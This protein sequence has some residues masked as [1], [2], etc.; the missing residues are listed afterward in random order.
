MP[1]AEAISAN[2]HAW[3][4]IIAALAKPH[5]REAAAR[6]MLGAT[7]DDAVEP[8]PLAKCDRVAETLRAAGLV[9]PETGRFD[10]RVVA[11]ILAVNAVAPRR[12]V[13][14]YLVGGR[15]A[16]YPA[17]PDARRELLSEVARRAF[18]PDEVLNERAIN[19]R[20]AVFSDDVAV[21]RRYL[22]DQELL[23]RRADGSEYALVAPAADSNTAE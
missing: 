13:D 17:N 5:S 4:P 10:D 20:L 1:H 11:R 21:L 3:R 14:R 22:V 8:L 19:E 7:L 9:D 2:P 18:R 16:Q 23:E 15:I 6:L 12:G